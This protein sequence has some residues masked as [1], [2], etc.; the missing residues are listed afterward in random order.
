LLANQVRAW[1]FG[2]FPGAGL[3][4]RWVGVRLVGLGLGLHW[5]FAGHGLGVHGASGIVH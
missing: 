3:R 1:F 2:E 4:L 5:H